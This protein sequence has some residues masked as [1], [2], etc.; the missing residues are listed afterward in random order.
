MVSILRDCLI[1]ASTSRCKLNC[2]YPKSSRLFLPAENV[3]Q[4]KKK[5]E[6][7]QLTIEN[8]K[9][10]IIENF[11]DLV[12][13]P[14]DSFVDQ[15]GSL[16]LYGFSQFDYPN[17]QIDY[18]DSSEDCIPLMWASPMDPAQTGQVQQLGHPLGSTDIKS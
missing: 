15:E 13:L 3:E 16:I 12:N 9:V 1:S 10:D 18:V 2:M 11:D 14:L 6:V 8:G 4:E 17:L 7:R 5:K